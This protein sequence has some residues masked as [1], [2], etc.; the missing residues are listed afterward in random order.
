MST[1]E[2]GAVCTDDGDLA[3]MLRIVRSN[4]WDRNLNSAQQFKWRKA[5][6]IKSEFEAKYTFYDLGYNF[7]PSEITGFLGRVQLQ[8]LTENIVKRE[9]NHMIL[10][11]VLRQNP[12]LIPI[13]HSHIQRLSGF[14]FPVPVRHQS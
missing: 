13:D 8:Y 12:D 5:F 3:E 6:N 14:A 1:I 11:E 9:S 7:R 4:G 10:E 2:G